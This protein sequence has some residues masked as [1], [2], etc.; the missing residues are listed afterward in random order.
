MYSFKNPLNYIGNKECIA[1]QILAAMPPHNI[2][3]EPC[4]GS[5]EVFFRKYP[6]DLEILN[7]Y[8]GD[9]V[10]YFRTVQDSDKLRRLLGRI[11]LSI[12]SELI[13]RANRAWM[14]NTDNIL[15]GVK[16]ISQEL[17][18]ANDVDI[19]LAA[20]FF[21]NQTYSFSSTGSSFGI[22]CRDI[23][24]KI[25]LL[26]ASMRRL[27]HATILHRDYKEVITYGARP[28]AFIFLDPPY[29]GTERMY[30]K[31]NFDASSHQKLF[32][33]MKDEV[34][35]KFNG[36]CKFIITYNDHEDIRALAKE[37]GFFMHTVWRKDNLRQSSQPGS[38]Y[39]ELMIANYDMCK[40]AEENG[41]FLSMQQE[42]LFD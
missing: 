33:F 28:N 11:V 14:C 22:G 18:K 38:Q 26:I 6:V 13:F 3:V 30:A 27:Q 10:N 42:K 25:P 9:V 39:G 7:D 41:Y 19:D 12:N 15:D 36:Q 40:Q 32:E 35:L 23:V 24:D 8:S 5:A 1:A 21:E 34:D 17:M 2:Y 20:A 16:S 4:M 37:C 31:G 29:K